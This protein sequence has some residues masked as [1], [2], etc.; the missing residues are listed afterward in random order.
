M[1]LDPEF[2]H[3]CEKCVFLGTIKRV[4]TILV[5]E[6]VSSALTADIEKPSIADLAKATEQLP[7]EIYDLYVCPS[8]TSLGGASIIA[9]HGHDGPDYKSAPVWYAPGPDREL[10]LGFAYAKAAGLI[11]QLKPRA[12]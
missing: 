9:R 6:Q 10:T 5:T 8:N 12:K 2:T 3:D 1:N 7:L 4:E 11:P